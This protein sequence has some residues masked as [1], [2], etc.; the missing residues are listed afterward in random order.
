M[1]LTVDNPLREAESAGGVWRGHDDLPGLECA[2]RC[3]N[4][5]RSTEFGT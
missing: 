3:E 1:P 5:L 4:A 2:P